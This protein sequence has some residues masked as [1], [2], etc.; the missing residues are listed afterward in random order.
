MSVKAQEIFGKL[1]AINEKAITAMRS[2]K[3][4]T[5][6]HFLHQAIE[7]TEDQIDMSDAM[8]Q[9]ELMVEAPQNFKVVGAFTHSIDNTRSLTAKSRW[10]RQ[11]IE[12]R[13]VVCVDQV[14]TAGTH[15]DSNLTR[16][17]HWL[18]HILHRHLL[19][20]TTGF[21]S[22]CSYR[23]HRIFPFRNLVTNNSA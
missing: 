15:A 4:E 19:C 16:R 7:E 12:T 2:S 21:N 13:P 3:M 17:R 9:D 5:A 1:V 11:W 23:A 10:K 6:V 8:D 14:D 20:G 22:H 18:W